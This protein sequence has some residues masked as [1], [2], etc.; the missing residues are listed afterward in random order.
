MMASMEHSPERKGGRPNKG[1]TA[2]IHHRCTPEWL[3]WVNE[4]AASEDEH[5]PDLMAKAFDAYA[6]LRRFKA[7]PER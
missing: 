7:P 3:A 6:R 1:R 5:V 2:H 4:F